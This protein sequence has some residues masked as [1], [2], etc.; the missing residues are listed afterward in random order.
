MS[1]KLNATI[2]IPKNSKIK[3]EYN[4]KSNTIAVDRIL[5]GASAYPMNY[6][7]I[8]NTLDWDGDEL[9]VLIIADQEFIPGIEVP[10]RVVGAMEMIDG[11]ETDTKLLGVIDCDVRYN[12]INKL[13]DVNA[14]MLLEIKDFFENYKNLQSKKVLIKGFQDKDWAEKEYHECVELRKKYGELDNKEFIALMKKKHPE[15]YSK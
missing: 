13:A 15:K 14:H 1:L 9:D 7:F 11:G 3:Y 12:H 5:Y 10:I 6:G 4:R 2:E 8:K